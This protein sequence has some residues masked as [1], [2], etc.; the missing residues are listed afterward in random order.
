MYYIVY[1]YFHTQLFVYIVNIIFHYH[2]IFILHYHLKCLPSQLPVQLTDVADLQSSPI[3]HYN[4]NNVCDDGEDAKCVDTEDHMSKNYENNKN[5]KDNINNDYD[6]ITT[7]DNKGEDEEEAG[8]AGLDNDSVRNIIVVRNCDKDGFLR[9]GG[10]VTNCIG[11]NN[12]GGGSGVLGEEMEVDRRGVVSENYDGGSGDVVGELVEN[13]DLGGKSMKDGDVVG[14]KMEDGDVVGDEMEDGDVMEGKLDNCGLDRE[15]KDDLVSYEGKSDE[16]K[17]SE[18]GVDVK[19]VVKEVSSGLGGGKEVDVG[20]LKNREIGI[21]KAETQNKTESELAHEDKKISMEMSHETKGSNKTTNIIDFSAFNKLQSIKGTSK[22]VNGPPKKDESSEEGRRLR[23]R[24]TLIGCGE[25]TPV[26]MMKGLNVRCCMNATKNKNNEGISNNIDKI[27]D[28]DKKV[29]DDN[30]NN[31]RKDNR[32]DNND[33]RRFLR[34]RKVINYGEVNLVS[35]DSDENED[36]RNNEG[37]NGEGTKIRDNP[38]NLIKVGE[39][40][41]KSRRISKMCINNEVVASMT[42]DEGRSGEQTNNIRRVQVIEGPQDDDGNNNRDVNINNNKE[43]K[44]NKEDVNINN[45]EGENIDEGYKCRRSLRRKTVENNEILNNNDNKDYDVFKNSNRSYN[46]DNNINNKENK[47]EKDNNNNND[48]NNDDL[49]DKDEGTQFTR[50][51]SSV[52]LPRLH[53]PQKLK[54]IAEELN[55]RKN[56]NDVFFNDY[57]FKFDINDGEKSDE[58]D[59]RVQKSRQAKRRVSTSSLYV[60]SKINKQNINNKEEIKVNSK[61]FLRDS[62]YN[63]TNDGD[64]GSVDSVRHVGSRGAIRKSSRIAAQKSGHQ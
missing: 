4:N 17:M 19:G 36:A 44:N 27:D 43:N 54:P 51:R 3:H 58:D 14:D 57:S 7:I 64:T 49:E 47:T 45:N 26:K 13:G 29:D 22:H 40:P 30:N 42:N 2:P 55:N 33:T 1:I 62:N 38:G 56:K 12:N 10:G 35:F 11:I 60:K 61:D 41:R 37:K 18:A 46:V 52:C 48:A 63:C 16:K 34:S 21:I 20:G 5:K 59:V 53:T 39:T 28:K 23:R 6:S 31:N 25:V 15:R 9:D 32:I 8:D 24:R 50:L